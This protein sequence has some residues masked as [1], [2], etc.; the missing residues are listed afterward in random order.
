MPFGL[1]NATASH[2][3]ALGHTLRGL[4]WIDAVQYCHDV[5]IM[6]DSHEDH[7]DRLLKVL[8]RFSINGVAMKLSKCEF[9]V[10]KIDY[11]GHV[12]HAGKGIEQDPNKVKDLLER[13]RPVTAE[14]VASVLGAAGYYQKFVQD[15]TRIVKPIRQVQQECTHKKQK[16]RWGEEQEKSFCGL[17]AMVTSAPILMRPRFDG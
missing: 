3:R 13:P 4:L 7:M 8:T 16:I 11:V 17:K 15:H 2:C 10:E 6:G 5:T 1:K 12:V 9:G 14:E